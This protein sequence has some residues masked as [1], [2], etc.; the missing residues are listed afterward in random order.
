[1]KSAANAQLQRLLLVVGHEHEGGAQPA[2]QGGDLGAHLLAELPVQG[3]HRLVEE[4]HLRLEDERAGQGHPLALAARE[5]VHGAAGQL[6]QADEVERARHPRRDVGPGHV[7]HLEA[8]GD[9][10][11]DGAVREE[12]V[13]LEDGVHRAAVRRDVGHVAAG[14]EHAPRVGRVEPG[15]QPEERGLAAARRAE[16]GEEFAGPDLQRDLAHAAHGAVGLADAL[17]RDRAS[18]VAQAPCG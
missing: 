11:F 6:A 13:V 5:T 1:M 3:G 2:V 15:H 12:R 4:Q 16:E 10:A 17:E 7:R 14:E 18:G 9:V 8:E